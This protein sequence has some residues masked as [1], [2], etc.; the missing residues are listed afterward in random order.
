M[1]FP[2]LGRVICL[3]FALCTCSAAL[4]ASGADPPRKSFN[5]SG[6]DAAE[7]LREFSRQSGEHVIFPTDL[8]RG[9]RTNPVQG[10]LAPREALEKMI[11]N[12]NLVVFQDNASGAYTVT[13][14]KRPDPPKPKEQGASPTE[15]PGALRVQRAPT[16]PGHPPPNSSNPDQR[17]SSA[18]LPKTVNKPSLLALFS[19]WLASSAFTQPVDPAKDVPIVL[20]PFTVSAERDTGYR[21]T[22][23]LAGSRLNTPLSDIGASVSVVTKDLIDDLGAT[24]LNDLLIYTAGTE[25][26]GVNGN[27]SGAVD[28]GNQETVGFGDRSSPQDTGRTRG[29]SGPTRTRNYFISG[30]PMDSYNTE[31]VTVVRG[32]NSVLF[33]AGSPAG[34]VET[35]LVTADT[36]STRSKLEF[37]YG[38]NDSQRAILDHNQVLIRGKLAGRFVL[39]RDREKFNQ[40]PAYEDKDRGF[41]TIAYTPFRSTSIRI[42]GETGKHWANRPIATL[43]YNSIPDGWFADGKPFA[44]WLYYDD[45]ALNPNAVNENGFNRDAAGKPLPY[46]IGDWINQFQSFRMNMFMYQTPDAVAPGQIFN[47]R[48]ERAASNQPALPAFFDKDGSDDTIWWVHTGNIGEV[49]NVANNPAYIRTG[50]PEFASGRPVGTV[51]QGFTDY[52]TFDFRNQ[53]IDRTAVFN[54]RFKSLNVAIE[55]RF[56][57]DK[58]GVQF[59]YDWQNYDRW[60]RALYFSGGNQ[61]HIR[62]DATRTLPNGK[63]NPNLGRPFVQGG[64][65]PHFSRMLTDNETKRAT[66]YVRYDFRDV[67]PRWGRWIG[68]HTLTG[69]WEEVALRRISYQKAF[70]TTGQPGRYTT[71]NNLINGFSRRPAIITYLGPS[72]YQTNAVQLSQAASTAPI[73]N[74]LFNAEFYNWHTSQ[75]LTDTGTLQELLNGGQLASEDIETKAGV[76]QSYLLDNHLVSLIGVRR[77]EPK[78]G[79]RNLSLIADSN[80]PLDQQRNLTQHDY[81]LKDVTMPLIDRPGRTTFTY[82]GVLKWP[83]KLVALPDGMDLSFFF[84]K[85]ENFSPSGAA[86]DTLQNL[87]PSP[88]GKTRDY[89]FAVD[90]FNQKLSLRVNRYETTSQDLTRSSS[91]MSSA[92]NN[93]LLQRAAIWTSDGRADR[94]ADANKLLAVFPELVAIGNY[95]VITTNGVRTAEYNSGSVTANNSDTASVNAEGYEFEITYNP[96]RNWRIT[97]NAARQET[98]QT[99]L[100]P[101]TR[102]IIEK[103][104][105]VWRSIGNVPADTY[106]AGDV[107]GQSFSGENFQTYVDRM[108]LVPLANAVA[109]EGIK[110]PE[111][112]EWRFNLIT[113]YSFS[114]DSPI[115]PGLK[116][117]NIG[118]GVRWQSKAAVGYPISV[119]GGV[120][121]VDVENPYFDEAQLNVDAWIGYRRKIFNGRVGWRIQLNVT[122]LTTGSE[123]IVVRAQP[124]GGAAIVRI[125]PEQRW[126][127]TNTFTF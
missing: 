89:G 108:F 88:T 39:L 107:P 61:N 54:D 109:Q 74:Q 69:L 49:A 124:W 97:A 73:D 17:K 12:T 113:N 68:S 117:F 65:N 80:V 31:S 14:R 48:T 43:P 42:N 51:F 63:P 127:V 121:N 9:I 76:L 60:N 27:Y 24:S 120:T 93:G 26:S 95:R 58:V 98:I 125:P 37:R 101:R 112:R 55:Q 45:P 21:A 102:A 23:T 110:S 2:L 46:N 25:A 116:G 19:A 41:A 38:N 18:D 67:S 104:T 32:P 3:L 11:A 85:S 92:L 90:L 34:V 94:L 8:V 79:G 36:R 82:S 30:M 105:P 75:Y 64:T 96:T 78:F 6:G 22:S 72:V 35:S 71:D 59:E 100:L 122:N 47:G 5:V 13:S 50:L 115:L 106:V 84:N 119:A 91:V 77:D 99:D 16:P 28:Y 44:D 87:L 114:T 1:I 66:G 103:L 83:K 29:L 52:S 86:R 70:F 62:I 20:S 111:Q 81:S 15:A 123:P 56:W 4:W 10:K 126:Y 40:D 53:M 7:T 33:G 118:T 57:N